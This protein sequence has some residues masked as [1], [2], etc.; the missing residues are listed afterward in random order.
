M[1]MWHIYIN[2]IDHFQLNGI[3]FQS[4]SYTHM[5]VEK[6]RYTA[7]VYTIRRRCNQLIEQYRNFLA[8]VYFVIKVSKFIIKQFARNEQ[9]NSFSL[10]QIPRSYVIFSLMHL[11][12]FCDLKKSNKSYFDT[13]FRLSILYYIAYLIPNLFSGLVLQNKIKD[14]YTLIY[15]TKSIVPMICQGL[16]F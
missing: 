2:P 5:C 7:C 11:K 13:V 15:V 6:L 14:C 16:S 10:K 1:A 9:C 4:V 3:D 8:T 12:Q